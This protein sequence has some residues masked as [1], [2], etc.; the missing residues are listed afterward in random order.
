[1]FD[2]QKSYDDMS[3]AERMIREAL[4]EKSPSE[5]LNRL[6]QA[7][8]YTPAAERDAFAMVLIA[9]LSLAVG[10]GRPT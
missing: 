4:T 2:L 8:D 5:R 10:R 3:R 7:W 9:H 1:M 6:R